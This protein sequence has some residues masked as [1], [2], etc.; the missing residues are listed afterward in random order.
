MPALNI[1]FTDEELGRLR[2]QAHARGQSM[3]TFAH[4]LIVGQVDRA[5]HN[6]MVMSASAR[7]MDLSRDLLKRLADR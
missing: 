7:V 1:K 3:T 5:Q 6:E 2:S 4:D